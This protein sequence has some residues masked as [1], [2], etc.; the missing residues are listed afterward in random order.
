[1][2]MLFVHSLSQKKIIFQKTAETFEDSST[3]NERSNIDT[4]AHAKCIHVEHKC[5]MKQHEEAKLKLQL[6]VYLKGRSTFW[7]RIA[8][9]SISSSFSSLH[10][11]RMHYS[12]A[13]KNYKLI[14]GE[15][16]NHQFKNWSRTPRIS[17][18]GQ[19]TTYTMTMRIPTMTQMKSTKRV[20]AW[21]T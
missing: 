8:M 17:K 4:T 2:V 15:K 6:S 9:F 1:M 12:T 10:I 5:M 18:E 21:Y 14:R 3:H 13:V 11:F 19:D 20:R 7:K 16:K